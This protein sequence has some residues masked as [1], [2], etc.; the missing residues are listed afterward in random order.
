MNVIR[1]LQ[2]GRRGIPMWCLEISLPTYL[3]EIIS[4]YISSIIVRFIIHYQVWEV[5]RC[6]SYKILAGIKTQTTTSV[7]SYLSLT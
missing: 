6:L 2:E 5:I 3:I 7:S 1:V 4:F